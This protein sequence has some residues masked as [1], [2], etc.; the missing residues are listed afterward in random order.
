M[1]VGWTAQVSDTG[2]QICT[3]LQCYRRFR[4]D[5]GRVGLHMCKGRWWLG[6]DGAQYPAWH[7]YTRTFKLRRVWGCSRSCDAWWTR[8]LQVPGQFLLELLA[9]ILC[10]LPT[11][12]PP[13]RS[14]NFMSSICYSVASLFLTSVWFARNW[15]DKWGVTAAE[16]FGAKKLVNEVMLRF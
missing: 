2:E 14:V 3:C 11:S 16:H 7:R 8:C 9:C 12:L 1:P 13:H 4:V 15:R 10:F 6:T 5:F